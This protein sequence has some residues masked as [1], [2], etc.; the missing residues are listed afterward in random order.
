MEVSFVY[1]CSEN[2]SAFATFTSSA[3]VQYIWCDFL[4]DALLIALDSIP[5]NAQP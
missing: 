5:D 4:E 3:V 1:N 2:T